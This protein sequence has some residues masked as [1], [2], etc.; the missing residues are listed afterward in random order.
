MSLIARLLLRIFFRE[1]AIEGRERLPGPGPAL[2]LPNHPNSLLDPLFVVENY[3]EAVGVVQAL[4]A[5]VAPS[6]VR[7]PIRNPQITNVTDRSAS[8]VARRA[9]KEASSARPPLSTA[10]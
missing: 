1:I 9:A 3:W 10:P 5:G 4:R 6:S 2:F 8:Q 7:R